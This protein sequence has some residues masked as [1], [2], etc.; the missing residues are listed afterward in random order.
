[1]SNETKLPFELDDLTLSS[2]SDHIIG[3]YAD[4]YTATSGHYDNMVTMSSPH[5]VDTIT[6]S[7][8]T[9]GPMGTPNSVYTMGS[10]GSVGWTNTPM[11]AES[12]GSLSLQGDGADITINGVKLSETLKA[13]Q[14]RLNVL[15]PNPKL[16]KDWEDLAE[17]GRQYRELEKHITEKMA[18][19]DKLKSMPKID[20]N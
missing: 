10:T 13:L 7:P 1:M 9:I 20:V 5:N 14:Q 4:E 6:I 2:G 19:W 8:L 16:E 17:L 3:G 18:T 15:V 12:N 11:K